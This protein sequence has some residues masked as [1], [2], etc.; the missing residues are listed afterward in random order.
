M[1]LARPALLAAV[2]AALTL[3]A[4]AASPTL[5]ATDPTSGFALYR[6]GRIGA[7][8]LAELCRAGVEEMVVLDG[9]AGHREC[10]MRARV[11]PD[12]RI[13]YDAAQD[14]RIP[15]TS[16]FLG[17]FDAWVAEARASGRKIAF[18]CRHGWHRAGRLT[19]WYRMRFE[20]TGA[21]AAVE[22]MQRVGRMMFRHPQLEPQVH[23]MADLLAG[24]ECSTEPAHCVTG[25]PTTASARAFATD[26]CP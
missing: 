16:E 2:A 26:V 9:G 17:S 5:I 6:S 23:A 12:L 22:E 14:A 10:R 25:T 1:L 13:R 4:C 24:R 15:V 8:E 20:G 19:A 18:R 21:E 11:C 7:G 3:A